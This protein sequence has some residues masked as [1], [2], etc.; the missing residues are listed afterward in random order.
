MKVRFKKLVPG[1]VIPTKAHPSDAGSDL[2]CTSVEV[3]TRHNCVSY[4]TGLAVE[5]PEGYCG[6]L[7]PRPSVYKEDLL[8]TNAVG[9]IDSHYRGEVKMKFRIMQPHI[10]RYTVGDRIGQLVI[11]PFPSVEYEEAEELTHT[12]RGEGGCGSSGR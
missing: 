2:T 4:G 12:D 1:A 6:L 7:F 11:L 8:L 9:L 5:I 3:D 10:H